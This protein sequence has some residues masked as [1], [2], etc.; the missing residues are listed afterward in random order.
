MAVLFWPL[1]GTTHGWVFSTLML[2]A[3]WS[4]YRTTRS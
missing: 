3:I 4:D 1:Q 2:T